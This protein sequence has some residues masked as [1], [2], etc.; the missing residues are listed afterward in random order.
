MKPGYRGKHQS[1]QSKKEKDPKR[2]ADNGGDGGEESGKLV[3]MMCL[4]ACV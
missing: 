2:Q 4:E 1:R 3:G